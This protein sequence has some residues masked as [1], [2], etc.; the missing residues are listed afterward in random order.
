[1]GKNE[2]KLLVIGIDQAIPYLLRKFLKDGMLP[3]I[4]MLVNNGIMGEGYSCAPCDTPTN[5]TTIATGTT[6]AIHGVTSF[7]LHLPGESLD[8]G[9]KYR[10][11]TQL[12]KNCMAQYL[13]DVADDNGFK[14]FVLN[15]PSGWPSIFKNG[16]MSLFTW[17]IPSSLPKMLIKSEIHTI[18]SDPDNDFNKNSIGKYIIDII[19]NLSQNLNMSIENPS[20]YTKII[21]IK[22]NKINRE[23]QIYDSLKLTTNDKG[24]YE[25]IKEKEW[26]QWISININSE[27]GILPSLFRI[28]L[29]K[30]DPSGKSIQLERSG[31]YNTKGW[32]VPDS[33]GEKL[34]KNVFE[35]DLPKKMDVEF[36]IYGKMKHYLEFARNESL[37]LV[38]AIDFAKKDMDWDFCFF[39]YHPLDTIN[40]DLLAY[41][42]KDSRV[43]TEKKAEKALKN[44]E[45][46]YRIVDEMVGELMKRCIDK[47]T[48]TLFISDHGA[49]PIWKVANI[50][51][52]LI[53]AGLMDYKFN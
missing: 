41:L 12:Y 19:D 27:Y 11:R 39:H 51:K 8:L 20:H 40:H 48:I 22:L 14:P 35:Y 44:V 17:P 29:L 18:I 13:W 53:E 26:S 6:T 43:Y 3:N 36:M 38:Q 2:R 34:V 16:V 37:S 49:I 33:F 21:K 23:N 5:W 9:M 28:K 42:H 30:I 25:I 50:I 10:S 7:Y 24:N 4:Q 47:D 31:V 45:T 32:S 1:M 52:I 15:Y 46:A